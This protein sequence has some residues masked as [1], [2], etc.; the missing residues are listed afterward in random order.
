MTINPARL[1]NLESGVIEEGKVADIVIFNEDEEVI[2][3][4]FYSKSSNT[5]F[6]GEKLFGK[7]KY[8]ICNGEIVYNN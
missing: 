3:N 8:T 6:K 4:D 7:V 5:P 2:Y 1:Y